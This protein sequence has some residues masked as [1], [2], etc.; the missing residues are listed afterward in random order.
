MTRFALTA[1]G[2]VAALAWLIVDQFIPWF[3][4][5]LIAGGVGG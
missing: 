5:L 2:I 1:L 3:L 4:P